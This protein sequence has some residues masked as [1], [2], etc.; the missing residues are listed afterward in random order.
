VS[1]LD[2]EDAKGPFPAQ[3]SFGAQKVRVGALEFPCSSLYTSCMRRVAWALAIGAGLLA[4]PQAAISHTGPLFRAFGTPVIDAAQGPGEW[5][6]AS[7]HDFAVNRHP[8]EGGGTVTASLYV[9]NDGG[10]LYVALRVPNATVSDSRFEV[11]FDNNHD[12]VTSVGEDYVALTNNGFEDRSYQQGPGYFIWSPDSANGGTIDGAGLDGDQAGYSFYE[13]R[14][15][16]NSSDDAHDVSLRAGSRVGLVVN[17][18]H[19]VGL[20]T[21][22]SSVRNADLVVVSGTRVPPDTQI[23][24]GPAQGSANRSLEASFAFVGTDDAIPAGELLFECSYDTLDWD[25]CTAPHGL[26]TEDGRHTFRVR[27]IDEAGIVDPSPAERT[28]TVDSTEPSKPRVRG[29]RTTKNRRPSFTFS[30]TDARTPRSRIRFRCAFDSRRLHRCGAR[31]RQ[32]LRPGR[33]VLRVEAL[34]Q[35]GNVSPRATVGIRVRR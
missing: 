33:H 32:R 5:D 1:G 27:S 9:M 3:I 15:P 23:T 7:R 21:S 12:Q 24:S 14:H 2:A 17:F 6:G 8:T 19:C 26:S 35:L 31:Y 29:P 4:L 13:L 30:S 11:E 10:N 22:R 25:R 20:C 34:D 16:L 28:W 18:T